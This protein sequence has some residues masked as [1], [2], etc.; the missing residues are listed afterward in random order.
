MKDKA[1][2]IFASLG[3]IIFF[4]MV[5]VILNLVLHEFVFNTQGV[6]SAAKDKA[7]WQAIFLSSYTAFLATLI[8]SIFGTPLAYL[9][10]RHDFKGKA[11][12]EGAIDLPVVIPH[13]VAGIALL[14]VF[15]AHGLIGEFSPIRFVDAVPGIVIAMLF[16]SIPF[17]INH[18]KEGFQ[19]ID[20]KLENV[21]RSLGAN[22]LQAFFKVTLPL[23]Y[24]SLLAGA[25]MCWARA[26]SEFGAVI[27]IAYYPMIAP[28][29]IYERFIS[30]GLRAS[31]PVAAILVMFSLFVFVLV[32][33]LSRKSGSRR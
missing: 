3:S 12:V 33:L 14:L 2:I 16:V 24:T 26:I 19:S 20:P 18:A 29:L 8:A 25:I 1:R 30:S 23:A 21:A 13:T 32:R 31:S 5:V 27:V 22:H 10:A 4:F 6:I 11:I 7:V 28:T 15:G 9:L 17:F